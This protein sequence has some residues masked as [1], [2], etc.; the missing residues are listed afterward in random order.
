MFYGREDLGPTPAQYDQFRLWSRENL[1]KARVEAFDAE[2]D[3]ERIMEAEER[4]RAMVDDHW[5][6]AKLLTNALLQKAFELQ[7][8]PEAISTGQVAALLREA[9]QTMRLALGEPSERIE[10]SADPDAE[11]QMPDFDSWTMEELQQYIRL[12]EKAHGQKFGP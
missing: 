1:W 8:D 6:V 11:E 10:V 4:R 5:R 2:K 9:V 12:Q 7:R 3:V